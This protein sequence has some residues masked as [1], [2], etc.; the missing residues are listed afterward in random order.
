MLGTLDFTGSEHL[1][2]FSAPYSAAL[3]SLS[4]FAFRTCK[5]VKE[6]SLQIGKDTHRRNMIC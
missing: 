3:L 4:R 1:A 5:R 2:P 6:L